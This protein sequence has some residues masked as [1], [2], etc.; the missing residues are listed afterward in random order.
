MTTTTPRCCE[1]LDLGS[2]QGVLA[3]VEVHR[4]SCEASDSTVGSHRPILHS[5]DHQKNYKESI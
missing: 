3:V 4:G 5:L 2:Y 1:W